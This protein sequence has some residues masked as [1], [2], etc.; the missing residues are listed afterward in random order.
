MGAIFPMA[1]LKAR[2][3]LLRKR[4]KKAKRAAAAKHK[5][6][7]AIAHNEARPALNGSPTPAEG[8]ER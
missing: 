5:A 8:V 7:S 6:S 4:Q 3:G 1:S 2:Q